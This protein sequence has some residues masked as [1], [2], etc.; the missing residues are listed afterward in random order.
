[1]SLER[2]I[3]SWLLIPVVT[4]CLS[5]GAMIRGRDFSLVTT[6]WAQSASSE[7]PEGT[8]RREN[9][10]LRA[11]VERLRAD[12]TMRDGQ[13]EQQRQQ[14]QALS[15]QMDAVRRERNVAERERHQARLRAYSLA[16]ELERQAA[17]LKAEEQDLAQRKTAI[18]G[19]V[20][21]SQTRIQ[22][23]EQQLV[24]E[25]KRSSESAPSRS[26]PV[27]TTS[28]PEVAAPSNPSSRTTESGAAPSARATK[29]SEATR[30]A[31]LERELDIEREQRATLEQ[32]VQR[33]AAESNAQQQLEELNRS[34]QGARAQVLVLSNHLADERRERESL[35]VALVQIRKA[36]GVQGNS[37]DPA[38]WK[39]LV[40]VMESRRAEADR[41]AA[42]LRAANEAIVRLKGEIEAH[43]S[44]EEAGRMLAALEAENQKLRAAVSA[45][46]EANRSLRGKADLAERLA[47]MLYS[48]SGQ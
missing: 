3:L 48:G 1:M 44:S 14:A 42:E 36:A 40:E 24:A 10:R 47:E 39:R 21:K 38:S 46:E 27:S 23:L 9:E 5:G 4:P 26:D 19:E 25:R 12:L 20:K 15:R 18:D 35:E 6:V 33:L 43:G 28:R 2:I 8:L 34:L 45:A 31:D 11:T 29:R 41:L 16:S 13:L 30:V 37:N 7:S 22:D 17:R 32:E